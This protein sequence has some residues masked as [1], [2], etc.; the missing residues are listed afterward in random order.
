ALAGVPLA[1]KLDAPILLTQSSKL[2][3]DTLREIKRLGA[4]NVVILGGPDAV[5]KSVENELKAAKLN[6]RR[7]EGNNR[8]ETAVSI[9]KE[10]HPNG[11]KNIVVANGMDF[12]DALSVASYSAS[13]GIPIFLTIGDRLPEAT[14]KAV[15]NLGVNRTTVIG[16]AKA[17]SE[18][19]RGQL[20]NA[21][22]WGGNDRYETNVIINEKSNLDTA[23]MYVATGQNYADALTGAVLAA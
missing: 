20:P 3:A 4:K 13:E 14:S 7:I 11:V 8:F 23:H 21:T 6:V 1:H 16:G 22:R 5:N 15:K 12:P 18:K 19:V 17:V 10:L 9:A 2:H